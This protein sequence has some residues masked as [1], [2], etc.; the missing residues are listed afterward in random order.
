MK[1]TRKLIECA[2]LIAIAT[3]LSFIKLVDLP[4]GGSITAASMLPMIIISYRHGLGLGLASGLV[5]GVIQQLSGLNTLSWV[6][7]WQSVVAVI[8]LDYV[9]AFAVTGFGGVFKNKVT[10]SAAAMSLGALLCCILRYICHVISGC[11][12]WAG[13][14]IPTTA[15][16]SYSFIY[17]AT[18]MIPETIV[19][20]IAAYYL[21]SAM[22]FDKEM[23]VRKKKEK[24]GIYYLAAGLFA[25]IALIYDTV[26]IFS[27]LQD[28]E[29]GEFM[30]TNIVNA[31][32]NIVAIVSAI[33]IVFSA[34][35]LVIARKNKV[36]N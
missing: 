7:T 8:L 21:A 30:L 15:A 5:Y 28:G 23:P 12:V 14:S 24:G 1:K 27:V 9:I 32:W 20:V 6:T 19:L 10:N 25:A 2:L 16:L 31:P 4:Y 17:N 3:V 35:F 33:C 26:S 18:Y 11:T 29:S 34:V 13:L 36:N 22:D